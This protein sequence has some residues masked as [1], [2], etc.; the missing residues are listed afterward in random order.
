LTSVSLACAHAINEIYDVSI[1]PNRIDRYFIP[2]GRAH[3]FVVAVDSGHEFVSFLEMWIFIP[4]ESGVPIWETDILTVTPEYPFG[5]HEGPNYVGEGWYFCKIEAPQGQYFE[6]DAKASLTFHLK[7]PKTLAAGKHYTLLKINKTRIMYYPRNQLIREEISGTETFR[8]YVEP[9]ITPF[10]TPIIRYDSDSPTV[11][12]TLDITPKYSSIPLFQDQKWNIKSEFKVLKDCEINTLELHAGVMSHWSAECVDLD[13][14]WYVNNPINEEMRITIS[15]SS[16]T[17]QLDLAQ[18]QL[19]YDNYWLHNSFDGTSFIEEDIDFMGDFFGVGSYGRGW[20]YDD[21]PFIAWYNLFT[22]YN[23]DSFFSKGDKVSI[24]FFLHTPGLGPDV[25]PQ[26]LVKVGF[27]GYYEDDWPYNEYATRYY[28][29]HEDS[30]LYVY[31]DTG[32]GFLIPE[33]P[34]GTLSA[35]LATGLALGIFIK[36]RSRQIQTK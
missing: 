25:T 30:N 7:T 21:R 22:V 14:D 17:Y 6:N 23:V 12:Y 24:E 9:W 27:K 15:N 33:F 2:Q 8:F 29:E 11:K 31:F 34:F 1:D 28:S 32:P 4:E 19:I 13:E 10:D 26:E 3:D 35:I 16:G 18:G 5:T 20:E 36:R